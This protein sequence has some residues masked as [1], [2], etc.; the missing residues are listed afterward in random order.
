[1]GDLRTAC[2]VY[3]VAHWQAGGLRSADAR[4]REDPERHPSI[5]GPEDRPGRD[6]GEGSSPPACSEAL[7]SVLAHSRRCS[8]A[9]EATRDE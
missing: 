6:R 8:P 1:M 3:R 9:V 7:S 2:R 4:P 5:L